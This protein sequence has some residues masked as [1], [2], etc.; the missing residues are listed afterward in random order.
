MAAN[1]LDSSE[2]TI[3][4]E[5]AD[6]LTNN[7]T[8]MT[9]T[10]NAKLSKVCARTEESSKVEQ[11]ETEQTK[12]AQKKVTG[13]A[14]AAERLRQKKRRDKQRHKHEI[15]MLVT[16]IP[17]AVDATNIMRLLSP[18]LAPRY[19]FDKA[20]TDP[21]DDDHVRSLTSQNHL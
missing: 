13:P 20:L 9:I 19:T 8:A 1:K 5:S 3:H 10:S 17:S 7:N 11:H 12:S 18:R 14:A 16:T 21:A 6:S 2:T 15:D 4:L